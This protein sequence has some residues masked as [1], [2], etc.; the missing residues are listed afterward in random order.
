MSYSQK[1]SIG[2]VMHGR[3]GLM[4]FLGGGGGGGARH[5]FA[6]PPYVMSHIVNVQLCSRLCS[7][8]NNNVQCFYMRVKIILP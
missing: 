4:L 1:R 6:R 7:K 5:W 8:T 3:T 2:H